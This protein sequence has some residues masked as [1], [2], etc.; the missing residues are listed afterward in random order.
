MD[1]RWSTVAALLLTASAAI[2]ACQPRLDQGTPA[3]SASAHPSVKWTF[4]LDPSAVPSR[5]D[6]GSPEPPPTVR[7]IA[8]P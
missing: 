1:A 6:I 4:P 5:R 3:P 2:A 8:P 7:P